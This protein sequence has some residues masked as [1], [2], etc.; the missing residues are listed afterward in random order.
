[1]Q[2]VTYKKMCYIVRLQLKHI[3]T[4]VT[5]YTISGLFFDIFLFASRLISL[6]LVNSS[7]LSRKWSGNILASCVKYFIHSDDVFGIGHSGFK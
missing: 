3:K 1:M 6:D 7:I 2:C 5:T 4:N